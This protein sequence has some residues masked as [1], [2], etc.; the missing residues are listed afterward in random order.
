[1]KSELARKGVNSETII[2]LIQKEQCLI[3]ITKTHENFI[4]I[5]SNF[6][7]CVVPVWV[8]VHSCR[9][10][11]WIPGAFF[12]HSSFYDTSV[13]GQCLSLNLELTD[14]ATS[15]PV[16]REGCPAIPGFYLWVLRIQT[17]VLTFVLPDGLSPQLNTEQFPF[18]Y[19]YLR[20]RTVAKD[21]ADNI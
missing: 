19:L 11:R 4:K 3:V 15:W 18:E 9:G 7:I 21:Q 12:S 2:N 20:A 14:M 10:Q 16:K 8:C 6:F 13:I 17:Q 1:M 5:Y